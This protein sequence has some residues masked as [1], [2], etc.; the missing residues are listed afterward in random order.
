MKTHLL[1][2]PGPECRQ[3]CVGFWRGIAPV[4]K[5]DT[6]EWDYVESE[7]INFMGV[8]AKYIDALSK[9]NINIINKYNLTDLEIIGSTGSPLIHE[10]FD[11]IYKSIK[12][13]VSV[14][15]LSGGTDIV[16]CF[17][18]GNPMSVVRRDVSISRTVNLSPE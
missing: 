5:N 14:A 17:I 18:G 3:V 7:K 10:S 1:G 8:S 15:S 16:G 6:F 4:L 9:G 13:D 11:Y 12:K 2:N